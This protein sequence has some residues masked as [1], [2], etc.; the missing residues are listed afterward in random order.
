MIH[1]ITGGNEQTQKIDLRFDTKKA[2][3]KKQ[4]EVSKT[5]LSFEN[6]VATIEKLD[7]C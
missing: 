2:V 7:S 5:P 4:V 1:E 6:L 3:D